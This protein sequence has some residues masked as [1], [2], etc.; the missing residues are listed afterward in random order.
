MTMTK[1]TKRRINIGVALTALRPFGWVEMKIGT[2][3]L[4]AINEAMR[5][6][7]ENTTNS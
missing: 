1:E 7:E 2:K 3:A 6:L 4:K 5:Q